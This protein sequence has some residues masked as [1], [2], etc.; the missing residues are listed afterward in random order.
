MR[1]KKR[2]LLLNPPGDRIY[3]RDNYCSHVSKG[4][5]CWEPYDFLAVSD[6]LARAHE[7]Q[8]LDCIAQR[9]TAGQCIERVQAGRFD[10]LLL[11]TGAGSWRADLGLA[12]TL[13]NLNKSMLL[14]GTGDVLIFEAERFLR[15]YPCLDAILTDFTAGGLSDFICAP[16]GGPFRSIVTRQE[17]LAAP[18]PSEKASG[19]LVAKG[20]DPTAQVPSGSLV[21]QG[22]EPSR[23]ETD[24]SIGVPRH[25][26]FPLR[27]YTLPHARSL[28]FASILTTFGCPF[29]CTFCSFERL[30]FRR[31]VLDEIVREM[32]DLRAKGIRELFVRDQTFGADRSH[33]T[34]LLEQMCER[35]FTFNWS[36][37]TRADTIDAGFLALMKRAGC[38]LLMLGVESASDEV[39]RNCRK[40]LTV[41]AIREGFALCRDSGM[42]VLAHFCLGL[43]GDTEETVRKT[44]DLAMELEPDYAT[45]N[46]ATP[47]YGTT[48]R[49]AAASGGWMRGEREEY[50][51]S[52]FAPV[53]E[54]PELPRGKLTALRS[55]AIRRFYG[56]PRYILKRALGVRSVC[57]A[58][59]LL[60]EGLPILLQRR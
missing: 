47:R 15:D 19:S 34:Q 24:F 27:S 18:V 29:R 43:P 58:V 42:R 48:L 57:E 10:A 2:V 16:E 36:C 59:T 41:Q 12:N 60:R 9:L 8:V 32:E 53:M 55:E 13:K 50:D 23:D 31:R 45:F 40:G 44:I 26:L 3:I 56:N 22:P 46:I 6:D 51:P 7:V 20:A 21:A 17:D 52:G 39:L 14:V 28:P 30:P 25:D 5:Y 38:S 11:L 33:S 35:G 49:D 4:R 1:A 37:E 54:L